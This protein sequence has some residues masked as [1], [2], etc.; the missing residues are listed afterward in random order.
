M[1]TPHDEDTRATVGRLSTADLAA[2]RS[3]ADLPGAADTPVAGAIERSGDLAAA[4]A[5]QLVQLFAP[6]AADRFRSRWDAVQI[7]F[8]DDPGKAVREADEL[9]AE[10]MQSLADSFARERSSFEGEVQQAGNAS[11][12]TMRVAL[13]RYRSFFRRLLS[14]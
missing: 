9:V 6:D 10:V 4:Q 2:R 13:Q 11:T 5:E 3:P 1:N 8:V 14:L 7:G 12:E